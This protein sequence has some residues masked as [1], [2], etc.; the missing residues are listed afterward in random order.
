MIDKDIKTVCW[1]V[2]GLN[3]AATREAVRM[4]L[5]K[6]RPTIICLQETKL[7]SINAMLAAEFLVSNCSGSFVSLEAQQTRGGILIAW[8]Q[9]LISMGVPIKGDY[10]ITQTCTFLPS[11]SAFVITTVYGTPW[12]CL[13]DFNMICEA[14]D[15]KTTVMSTGP[16]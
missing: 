4:L 11:N 16:R 5:Q 3:N 1:N 13:G 9:D 14:R 2:R 12:L 8:D 15:K 7:D 6:I 10:S